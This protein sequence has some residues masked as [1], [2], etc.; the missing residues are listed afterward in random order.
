MQLK[1]MFLVIASFWFCAVASAHPLKMSFSKLTINSEG[2]VE[3]E[4]RIFLDDLTAHMQRL[5]RM[6]QP[7]FSNVTSNGTQALQRYINNHFY[8]EQ[9][10]EQLNLWVNSVSLSKNRLALVVNLSTTSSLD[11]TK[12]AFLV[13]TLM[14]DAFPI[15]T[16]DIKYQDEHYMLSI[17]NPKFKIQFD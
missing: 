10:G 9:D 3:L 2:F 13:N 16:N 12:E 11:T 1:G 6:Q 5:Y 7:D 15:Q 4:T 8:F 17:S 14:C